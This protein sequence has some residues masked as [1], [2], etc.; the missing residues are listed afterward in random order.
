[1]ARAAGPTHSPQGQD[2]VMAEAVTTACL[3]GVVEHRTTEGTSVTLFQLLHKPVLRVGLKVQG[4]GVAGILADE[5]TGNA[6]L[7]LRISHSGGLREQK[8][9]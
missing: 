5:T 8:E 4:N 9:K 7:F 6:S 3:V 2:A 1:M